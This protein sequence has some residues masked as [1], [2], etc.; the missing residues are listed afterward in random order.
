MQ[1][2]TTSIG[3]R[4]ELYL[5]ATASFLAHTQVR[6]RMVMTHIPHKSIHLS[7]LTSLRITCTM[8]KAVFVYD[9][10]HDVMLAIQ[11]SSIIG[12]M[13]HLHLG[14]LTTTSNH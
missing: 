7:P 5:A 8:Q 14:T 2:N 3:S 12:K 11:F 4:T 1:H 6:K 10:L 13:R 9:A